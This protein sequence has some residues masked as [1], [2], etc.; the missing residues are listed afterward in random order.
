MSVRDD[1]KPTEDPQKKEQIENII[2]LLELKKYNG[3]KRVEKEDGEVTFEEVTPQQRHM[4]GR[5]YL[6]HLRNFNASRVRKTA[7]DKT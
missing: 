4:I 3:K 7:Q 1:K 5:N 2:K 6:Q